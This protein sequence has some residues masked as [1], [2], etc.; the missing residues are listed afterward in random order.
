MSMPQPGTAMHLASVD[1]YCTFGELKA[2]AA[3]VTFSAPNAI[4]QTCMF[5]TGSTPNADGSVTITWDSS[6]FT[7]ATVE[8]GIKNLLNA[9]CTA[10]ATELGLTQSQ[11]QAVVTIRRVW[12]MTPNVQGGGVSTGQ[13][14]ITDYM[15]YP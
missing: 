5:D 2:A 4:H 13:A 15:A 11:V 6:W 8:T 14:A 9:V 12:A 7:Q 10:L 3:P 1:Y